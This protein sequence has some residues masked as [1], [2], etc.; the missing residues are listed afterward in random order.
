MPSRGSY[1]CLITPLP[2]RLYPPML[3]GGT[4][5]VF[6][7]QTQPS[8]MRPAHCPTPTGST[9][10]VSEAKTSFHRAK[11]ADSFTYHRLM[12]AQ[13]VVTSGT[14]RFGVLGIGS[15]D[16]GRPTSTKW[17]E[18]RR[19]SR[20]FAFHRSFS[21][22]HEE[23]RGHPA[24]K[25]KSLKKFWSTTILSR[26]CQA[27]FLL[28]DLLSRFSQQILAASMTSHGTPRGVTSEDAA[29]VPLLD[30]QE[31]LQELVHL[32]RT[33]PSARLT[34][35]LAGLSKPIGS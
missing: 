28:G 24:Q 1:S 14:V 15:R 13:G 32:P 7:R 3:P 33:W 12:V 20:N 19:R 16:L 17:R 10:T 31:K 11:E 23:T 30:G 21:Y 26:S 34:I 5:P 2:G 25:K 18:L 27:E 8:P 4:V 35:P 29:G 9:E 22:E 6:Q